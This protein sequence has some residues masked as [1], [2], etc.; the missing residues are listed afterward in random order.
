MLLDKLE[1]KGLITPPPFVV[2]NCMYMTIMGSHAYGV[3]DT[4]VKDKIPDYDVYGFCMP[5]KDVLFPHFEA[6]FSGLAQD[7]AASTSTKSTTS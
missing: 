6:K 2:S 5:P 3:A 7:I 4:S 1:K